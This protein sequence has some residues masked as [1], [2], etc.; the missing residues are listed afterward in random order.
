MS[1]LPGD[2]ALRDA[3]LTRPDLEDTVN[4]A[5]EVTTG[6]PDPGE[7]LEE[8]R[9]GSPRPDLDDEADEADVVEQ[10]WKVPESD[11]ESQP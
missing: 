1:T 10:A 3:G 5:E 4:L 6:E 9:P 8:Y 2:D 7:D 11:E